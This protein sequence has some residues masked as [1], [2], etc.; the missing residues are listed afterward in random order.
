MGDNKNKSP[1]S[2][3][4]A[5]D[6]ALKPKISAL[7]QCLLLQGITVTFKKRNIRINILNNI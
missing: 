6:A 1:H 4:K 2:L 7:M 5:N 3:A